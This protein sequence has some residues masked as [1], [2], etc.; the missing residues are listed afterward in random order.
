MIP[1]KKYNLF[2]ILDECSNRGCGSGCWKGNEICAPK[3][4]ASR[5][6]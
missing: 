6:K 1:E 4:T 2:S 3:L 5:W